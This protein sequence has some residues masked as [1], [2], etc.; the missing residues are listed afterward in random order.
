MGNTLTFYW[1]DIV[2]LRSSLEINLNEGSE[3]LVR[4]QILKQSSVLSQLV[5]AYEPYLTSVNKEVLEYIN[6][7]G[8]S[9][10]PQLT[11]LEEDDPNSV[12]DDDGEYHDSAYDSDFLDVLTE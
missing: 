11:L 10:V 5:R 9:T 7:F 1:E 8:P 6:R 2:H 4:L 12:S 3:A